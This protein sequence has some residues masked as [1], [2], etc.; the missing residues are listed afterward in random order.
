[1]RV[2]RFLAAPGALFIAVLPARADQILGPGRIDN[3]GR[4]TLPGGPKLGTYQNGKFTSQPDAITTPGAVAAGSVAIQGSGSTGD[5]S[6][7]S[8]AGR[9][10]AARAQ[11]VANVLDA[12]Y[13]ADG[14]GAA[15]STA[16]FNAAFASGK[17]IVIP[18]GTYSVCNVQIPSNADVE[19]AGRDLTFLKAKNGCNADVVSTVGAYSLFGTGSGGGAN[20]W[21]IS[22]L[23]IDGNRADQTAPSGG[24]PDQVNCLAAYGGAWRMRDV[25]LRNCLGNGIRSQWGDVELLGGLEASLFSVTIDTVG[26]HGWLFG[27]PHDSDVVKLIVTDAGQEKDNT[28]SGVYENGGAAR[29]YDFHAWHRAGVQNRMAYNLSS[30]G[31]NQITSSHFEGGH[32]WIEHRGS[33]DIITNSLFYAL[34]GINDTS[35]VVFRA[36]RN[37]HVGNHY[38]GPINSTS[39]YA[40]Q[41]GDGSGGAG[42]LETITSSSVGGFTKGLANFVNSTGFNTI[43]AT[44][45]GNGI[46]AGHP[47]VGNP[48]GSDSIRYRDPSVQTA[49]FGSSK[50]SVG[51][52]RAT[53]MVDV[54]SGNVNIDY[55]FGFR[56]GSDKAPT[57]EGGDNTWASGTSKLLEQGYFNSHDSVRLYTPGS[58]SAVPRITM[59][60]NAYNGVELGTNA[61][62][63]TWDVNGTLRGKV[64]VTSGAPTTTDIPNRF[65]TA[66]KRADD[67]SVKMCVNDDGTIRCVA[68]Q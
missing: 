58:S 56:V 53:Q 10:I 41:F 51:S 7:M 45:A 18:W 46:T 21:E 64:L 60:A 13:G 35:G 24:S 50:L 2:N 6:E 22:R 31:S 5:V 65:W 66:V 55:G 32:A 1:M 29:F 26:R 8:A 16:A 20:A 43:D 19:G 59:Q 4:V 11:D 57:A 47:Y 28:Y 27:G 36:P 39:M 48:N 25:T 15:D 30:N 9:T 14:T 44:G 33:D 17:R 63:A 61:P 54:T 37:T 42:Y 40:F 12:P 62:G 68:M 34:V 3:S 52:P 23:T 67:S 49:W 38:S